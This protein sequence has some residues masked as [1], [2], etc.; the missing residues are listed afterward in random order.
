MGPAIA[1]SEEVARYCAPSKIDEDGRRVAAFLLREGEEYLS[2]GWLG[3]ADING[4]DRA[5]KTASL[6]AAVRASGF[7]Y[8]ASGFLAVLSVGRT[9]REVNAAV[10][11]LLPITEETDGYPA[12]HAGIHN[13]AVDELNVASVI[14]DSVEEFLPSS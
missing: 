8:A 2:A 13:T 1:D 4:S 7:N 9:R 11:R 5:S 12:Y 3:S 14:H 6:K 10:N